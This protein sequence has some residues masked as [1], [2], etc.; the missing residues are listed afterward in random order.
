[1]RYYQY[2]PLIMRFFCSIEK[3]KESAESRNADVALYIVVFQFKF[4]FC[5]HVW[6]RSKIM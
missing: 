4:C 2:S 1:M 5:S 6:I 3:N